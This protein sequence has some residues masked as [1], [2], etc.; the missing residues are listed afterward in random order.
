MCNRLSSHSEQTTSDEWVLKL[1]CLKNKHGFMIQA[2]EVDHQWCVLDG[3]DSFVV[4]NHY[5]WCLNSI[6][7][8]RRKR[9]RWHKDI[10]ANFISCRFV[11]KMAFFL[12]WKNLRYHPHTHATIL[13]PLTLSALPPPSPLMH[14]H[15]RRVK[16]ERV[17]TDIPPTNRRAEDRHV[18]DFALKSKFFPRVWSQRSSHCCCSL[19]YPEPKQRRD[20]WFISE[21]LRR[22]LIHKHKAQVRRR[23]LRLLMWSHAAAWI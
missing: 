9:C 19:Q 10:F 1:A 3:T 22:R 5:F 18:D 7:A 15:L 12:L 4:I 17:R 8:V 21:S 16:R 11:C 6:V 14:L 13:S 23:E 2:A 20:Q